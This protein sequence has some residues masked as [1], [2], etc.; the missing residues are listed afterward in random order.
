MKLDA[1]TRAWIYRVIAAAVPLLVILGVLTNDVAAQLLN[2]AAALLSFG[3][4]A[5]A[6]K[7]ITPDEE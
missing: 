2:V 6:L 4:S 5:L 1:N 7:N 3:G